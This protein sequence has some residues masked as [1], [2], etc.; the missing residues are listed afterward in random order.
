MFSIMMRAIAPYQKTPKRSPFS[1]E[2]LKLSRTPSTETD[3]SG[4]NVGGVATF[5]EQEGLAGECGVL[6]QDSDLIGAIDLAR[7]S[8]TLCG[9]QVLIVNTNNGKSVT[10][11]I[12]DECPICENS[13]SFDLSIGAFEQI[14]SLEDGEVPIEWE[15]L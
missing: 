11:T 5:F 9:Q 15:F 4:F 8:S 14:A 2:A 13:N 10:I 1:S 12:A 6:H 3:N 7:F